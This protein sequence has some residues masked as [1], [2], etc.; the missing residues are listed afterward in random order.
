[1]A[2][3]TFNEIVECERELMNFF[4]WDLMIVTPILV[5]NQYLANGILY[6]NE[7]I[8]RYLMLETVRKVTDSIQ[9]KLVVLVKELNLF[10]DKRPS[11]LAAAL[12]YLARKEELN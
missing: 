3:P 4:K 2:S 8:D 5:L 12:I 10:R 9:N 6:D 11:Q 1:V 7:D